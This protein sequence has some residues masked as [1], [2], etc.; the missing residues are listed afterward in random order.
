MRYL[1]K[2]AEL[3][4]HHSQL[5]YVHNTAVVE[6]VLRATKRI[7]RKELQM[8]TLGA[9]VLAHHRVDCILGISRRV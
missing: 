9:C 4:S 3:A 5:D 8:G 7:F 2:M 1:G 6:M